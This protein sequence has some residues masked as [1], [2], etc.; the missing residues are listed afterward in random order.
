VVTD[1]EIEKFVAEVN[2]MASKSGNGVAY[3]WGVLCQGKGSEL[4]IA[5]HRILA[6]EILASIPALKEKDTPLDQEG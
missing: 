6:K 2:E 1:E 3:E 4:I 5:S